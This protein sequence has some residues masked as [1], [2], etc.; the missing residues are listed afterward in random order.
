[1]KELET[2]VRL[3]RRNLAK[4]FISS[5]E[6]AKLLEGLPDVADR[7]EWITIEDEDEDKDGNEE[8]AP[9]SP[10]DG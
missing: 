8:A 1:M 4:G 7:G 2:D 9:E 6:V 3:I 10:S 5:D